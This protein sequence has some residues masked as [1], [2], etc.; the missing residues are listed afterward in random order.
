M[1]ASKCDRCGEVATDIDTGFSP[2]VHEMKHD[3]GGTW[4][5]LT[6][7]DVA[8]E[9]DD[10]DEPTDADREAAN[11][12]ARLTVE[13]DDTDADASDGERE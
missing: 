12:F 4:R 5:V 9:D 13:L 11:T 10:D 6:D 7:A 3:C 8:R 2:G 1:S